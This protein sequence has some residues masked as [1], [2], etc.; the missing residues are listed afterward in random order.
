MY[1]PLLLGCPWHPEILAVRGAN[2]GIESLGPQRKSHIESVN[3]VWILAKKLQHRHWGKNLNM[4]WLL[5]NTREF[6]LTLVMITAL[7]L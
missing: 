6:L 2:R 7:L 5:G 4:E 1:D 3:L